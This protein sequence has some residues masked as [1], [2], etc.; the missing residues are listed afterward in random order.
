MGNRAVIAFRE[1]IGLRNS[2]PSVYLHWNGGLASVEG[3]LAAARELGYAESAL[4]SGRRNRFAKLVQAWFKSGS[5]YIGDYD[6]LDT[7]NLDNG[8]YI[9]SPELEI[10][11]RQFAPR[12]EEVDAEKTASIKAEL[13]AL[14]QEL[15]PD[16]LAAVE[17]QS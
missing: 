5:V 16:G 14:A 2:T 9:V 1:Q 6:E 7:N 12:A 4:A 10:E 15:G 17:L 11:E 13:L 8:T 3:F